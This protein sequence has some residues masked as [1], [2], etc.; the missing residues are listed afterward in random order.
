MTTVTPSW[1]SNGKTIP[2]GTQS[3]RARGDR[4]PVLIPREFCHNHDAYSRPSGILYQLYIITSK[5]LVPGTLKSGSAEG[6]L[7]RIKDFA[8]N[9]SGALSVRLGERGGAAARM[10]HTCGSGRPTCADRPL[11]G[12]N[13]RKGR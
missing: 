12:R 11:P 3:S 5:S 10:A 6:L 13:W 4:A 2:L 1:A 9:L 8:G 7:I